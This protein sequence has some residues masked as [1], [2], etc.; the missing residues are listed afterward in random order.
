MKEIWYVA[1]PVSGDIEGNLVETIKII[2]WLTLHDPAR[3]YI[4]P[5]VAEVTAF[6]AENC[7]P[8]FYDRVLADDCEVVNR[9][10]G[11]LL[12]GPTISRGMQ[13]EYDAAIKAGKKVQAALGGTWDHEGAR[14]PPSQMYGR[15]PL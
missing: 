7:D 9:L 2:K 15:L 13:L 4:A 12:T 8:A 5:W 11:V 6:K 3:I 14:M 1:H 10:D